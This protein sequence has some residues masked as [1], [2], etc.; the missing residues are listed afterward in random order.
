MPSI[1]PLILP[2]DLLHHPTNDSR[3]HKY[4]GQI[5]YLAFSQHTLVQPTS[6][7][8]GVLRLVL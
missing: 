7:P 5:I 2:N 8:I 3:T 1:L 6:Y 4:L